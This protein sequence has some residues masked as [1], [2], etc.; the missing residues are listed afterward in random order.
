MERIKYCEKK[1]KLVG[2]EDCKDCEFKELKPLIMKICKH[3]KSRVKC[4]EC[5][6]INE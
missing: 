5:G 4:S 3:S 1:E 6:K 2:K